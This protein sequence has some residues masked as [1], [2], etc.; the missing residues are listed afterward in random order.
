MLVVRED[1]LLRGLMEAYSYR[2]RCRYRQWI[3]K[4]DPSGHGVFYVYSNDP[5]WLHEE[6]LHRQ[7]AGHKVLAFEKNEGGKWRR[8]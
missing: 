2:I 4:P 6:A 7:R 8:M 5:S 3:G 1:D